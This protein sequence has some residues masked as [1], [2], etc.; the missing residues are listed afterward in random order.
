VAQGLPAGIQGYPKLL[1]WASEPA[2][3]SAFW[4]AFKN[5]V[6]YRGVVYKDAARKYMNIVDSCFTAP[7]DQV[8]V[9][10]DNGE[11]WTYRGFHQLVNG[12]SNALRKMGCIKGDVIGLLYPMTPHGCAIYLAVIQAGCVALTVAE[13]FS[14]KEIAIR[15]EIVKAKAIIVQ[16]DIAKITTT[17]K[18]LILPELLS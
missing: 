15:M 3:R 5:V 8:A 2:N 12:Y 14:E 11:E 16:V 18:T 9:R 10:G 6:G 4:D 7:P 17:L 1:K 13:S